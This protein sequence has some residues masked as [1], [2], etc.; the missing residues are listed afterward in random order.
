MY[1]LG[2]GVVVYEVTAFYIA[3]GG[4]SHAGRTRRRKCSLCCHQTGGAY[5]GGGGAD[6][7]DYSGAG[8]NG[9]QGAVRII[10]GDGRSYPS[11]NT[12]DV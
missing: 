9:T 8:G 7:D 6:D 4:F 12:G 11:T 2:G 1:R 5:G 3:I 10:W